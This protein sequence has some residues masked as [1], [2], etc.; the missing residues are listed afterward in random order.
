MTLL[1]QLKKPFFSNGSVASSTSAEVFNMEQIKE[2]LYFLYENIK[3]RRFQK[4]CFLKKWIIFS[5]KKNVKNALQLEQYS[6]Y[7]YRKNPM[8]FCR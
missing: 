8:H 7:M 6:T 4:S 5:R 3:R 2:F 1:W